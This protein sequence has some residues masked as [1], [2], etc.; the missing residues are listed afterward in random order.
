MV[1]SLDL[2]QRIVDLVASGASRRSAAH[3]FKVG[4]SSAIRFVQQ[5]EE[6]GHVKP[7]VRAPRRSRLDPFR[8][9]ILRWITGQPD[10]TLMRPALAV[11]SF[12]RLP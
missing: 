7:K 2:R 1:L 6:L 4:V 3:H 12:H 8:D 11:S 5:A 10:L 9:G